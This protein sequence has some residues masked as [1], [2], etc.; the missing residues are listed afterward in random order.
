MYLEL[1]RAISG[2][3]TDPN[4]TRPMLNIL[5]LV[6]AQ[7]KPY[8]WIRIQSLEAVQK[9]RKIIVVVESSFVLSSAIPWE[10]NDS[11]LVVKF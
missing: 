9:L 1:L 2:M 7:M 6:L 3:I 10:T 4:A 8:M 5:T 11:F